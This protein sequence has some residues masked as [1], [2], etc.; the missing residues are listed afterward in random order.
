MI[1]NLPFFNKM[2]T[3]ITWY[4]FYVSLLNLYWRSDLVVSYIKYMYGVL[5]YKSLNVLKCFVFR[6][7]NEIYIKL[8]SV[9]EINQAKS[10]M[11][12]KSENAHIG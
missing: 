7:N 5:F 1:E 10:T 4:D 3:H 9:N 2:G 8:S 12:K 6:F 11:K